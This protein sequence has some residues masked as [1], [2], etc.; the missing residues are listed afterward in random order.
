MQRRSGTALVVFVII[1]IADADAQRNGRVVKTDGGWFE[2]ARHT[3]DTVAVRA[4]RAAV[5]WGVLTDD[6]S[7]KRDL[8]LCS[9]RIVL[10][11]FFDFA[12][13]DASGGVSNY[14]W[15]KA[16][17][18]HRSAICLAW[19]EACIAA[20]ADPVCTA[21]YEKECIEDPK[22]SAERLAAEE[23]V[24]QEM[25]SRPVISPPDVDGQI[26]GDGEVT[27]AEWQRPVVPYVSG[28]WQV[29]YE[30]NEMNGPRNNM[31]Q[32]PCYGPFPYRYTWTVYIWQKVDDVNGTRR[33]T[34][35]LRVCW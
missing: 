11:E 12:D 20:L 32:N 34:G 28:I 21:E 14:E 19:K 8:Q 15:T 13:D 10:D 29:T 35:E 6:A 33:T 1:C 25:G 27:L 18:D 2:W 3:C 23:N 16:C 30:Y 9:R 5:D 22:T 31:E 26:S 4:R 7:W 17:A 24:F